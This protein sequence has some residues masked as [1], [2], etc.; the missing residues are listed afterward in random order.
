M[1]E[2]EITAAPNRALTCKFGD[3]VLQLSPEDVA[4]LRT[5]PLLQAQDDTI[6]AEARNLIYGER[7]QSHG[8][9]D[10]NLQAIARIWTAILSSHLKAGAEVSA[11]L[12]CLMMAGLKLAR[13]ANKPSHREHALDVVGYMALME[14]CEF[15]DA[16][17]TKERTA[18]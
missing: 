17:P 11:P 9:P 16:A 7:E 15:L 6:L 10:R 1:S 3:A 18:S 14:R 2:R 12:V 4:F 8:A 13:A 5:H